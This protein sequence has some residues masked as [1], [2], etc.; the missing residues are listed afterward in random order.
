MATTKIFSLISTTSRAIAP[1]L[2]ID[3]AT[4][5]LK[6]DT[7]W[8]D[9]MFAWVTV[10]RCA[11]YEQ[12]LNFARSF[13]AMDALPRRKLYAQGNL[14][15]VEGRWRD[16][17]AAFERAL[18]TPGD[19]PEDPE[20]LTNEVYPIVGM[21]D[22]AALRAWIKRALKT[23][24][25]EVLANLERASLAAQDGDSKTEVEALR[26]VLLSDPDPSD[27]WRAV[28][29]AGSHIKELKNEI[30]TATTKNPYSWRARLLLSFVKQIDGDTTADQDMDISS[31]YMEDP[32]TYTSQ[33]FMLLNSLLEEG[34]RLGKIKEADY[35]KSAELSFLNLLASTSQFGYDADV[36]GQFL[37][38]GMLNERNTQMQLVISRNFPLNRPPHRPLSDLCYY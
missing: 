24:G 1:N 3:A 9:K 11:T 34:Q 22:I 12:K 27:I 10:Q 15:N 36:W 13:A 17:I 4:R 29:I 5:I 21:G 14:A 37:S 20:L 31:L 16:S 18:K 25:C 33:F 35:R 32:L 28:L 23:K 6:M 8:Q 19:Y 2:R 26:Q 30:R 38:L 7:P